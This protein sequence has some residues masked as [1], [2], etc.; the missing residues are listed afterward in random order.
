MLIK[1]DLSVSAALAVTMA[2]EAADN[3]IKANDD[4][5]V[6][7]VEITQASDTR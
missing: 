4:M 6:T 7:L 2:A 5:T 1:G 3:M